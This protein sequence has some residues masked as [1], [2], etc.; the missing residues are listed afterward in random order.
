MGWKLEEMTGVGGPKRFYFSPS[1][2]YSI[3]PW[4]LKQLNNSGNNPLSQVEVRVGMVLTG[5]AAE[6][7]IGAGSGKDQP[8][9]H[10]L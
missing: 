7:G 3:S 9:G 5:W 8:Q 4:V 10:T 2:M 6:S 1:L